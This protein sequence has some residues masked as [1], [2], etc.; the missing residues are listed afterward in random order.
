ME[1]HIP[2]REYFDA[3]DVVPLYEEIE[4]PSVNG[5]EPK[6]ERSLYI[7]GPFLEGG[8]KNRN[9]RNKIL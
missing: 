6:K 5:A 1:N 4:L 2:L 9:G 7:Q 3:K 8:I